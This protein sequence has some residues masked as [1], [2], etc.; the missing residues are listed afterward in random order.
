MIAEIKK[1]VNELD[2]VV[3]R[4]DYER[5][6]K[7]FF[8]KERDNAERDLMQDVMQSIGIFQMEANK[9]DHIKGVPDVKS[10]NLKVQ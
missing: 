10:K 7:R 2:Y 9:L 8:G 1:K 3:E 6:R 5:R 4:P